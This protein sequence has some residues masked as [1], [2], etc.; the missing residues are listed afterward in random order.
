MHFIFAEGS[1]KGELKGYNI[2][3]YIPDIYFKVLLQ[4]LLHGN[5]PFLC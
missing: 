4:N 2:I 3:G 1:E 5:L